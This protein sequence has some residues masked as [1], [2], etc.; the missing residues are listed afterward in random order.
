[1]ESDISHIYKMKG[2]HRSRPLKVLGHIQER[3]VSILIDTGSDRDFLHPQITESLLLALSP[4][5]LFRV[6]TGN[7][8]AL[9]CTHIARQT[10]LEVQGYTFTVE[11]MDWLESF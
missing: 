5:R 3:K 11:G 1:M 4:I 10:L 6:I 7:G 8:G 2:G 9:L